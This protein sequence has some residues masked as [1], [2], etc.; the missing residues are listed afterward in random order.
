VQR[1][2][3]PVPS[4]LPALLFSAPWGTEAQGFRAALTQ[5][6]QTDTDNVPRCL[7]WH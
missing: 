4:Q 6:F 1:G 5:V 7:Y 3:T 2:A